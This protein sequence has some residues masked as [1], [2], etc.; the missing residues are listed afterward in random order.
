[1]SQVRLKRVSRISGR[2]GWHGLST[3]DYEEI[4]EFLVTG[5]EIINGQVAWNECHRVGTDIWERDPNIQLHLDDILVTK[6]GSI[7]KIAHI[8]RLPGSAT[9][10]SGIFRVVC[11]REKLIPKYLYWILHSS[12]FDRFVG[13]LGAGS[14]I[15]HLY[16]RDFTDFE[17]PLPSLVTQSA[18][19][20]FL[21]T[22][23]ARIDAFL[24]KKQRMAELLIERRQTLITQVVTKGIP[25]AVAGGDG[26]SHTVRLKHHASVTAGQSPPSDQ[27]SD[28]DGLG[29]PF[30]QGNAEFGTF[31][32]EAKYRCDSAR[33]VCVRG[34]ILLSVRAPVGALNVADQE[35]GIGRGLCA[36]QAGKIDAEFLWWVVNA[37]IDELASMAV[38]STYDAVT[39]EEVGN[40][41]IPYSDDKTQRAIAGYLD[42]ETA[43]IDSLCTKISTQ[44]EL[45]K[46]HR[47]ALITAAVTGELDKPGAA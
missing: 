34:A 5:T 28:F 36:I 10:N 38:G 14:T 17:F 35:Y 13:L 25:G 24:E 7:G 43:K 11:G 45:L 44:I 41:R 4:G 33:K 39:T 30:L 3:S 6:D 18:V 19:A 9:L 26:V 27:V 8:D 1:M 31:N 29:L 47:Q 21:D 23:T 46:E 42:T 22:E 16:Q 20:D 32:P 12:L 37:S 15:S 2:I 40:I